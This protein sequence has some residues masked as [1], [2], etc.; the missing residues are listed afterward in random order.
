M[1]LQGL[2]IYKCITHKSVS[3]LPWLQKLV[4]TCKQPHRLNI[5]DEPNPS[6]MTI[7]LLLCLLAPPMRY[8]LNL[9]PQSPWYT[10]IKIA[11]YMI[12]VATICEF[13][14]KYMTTAHKR[15]KYIQYLLSHL[16]KPAGKALVTEVP[17]ICRKTHVLLSRSIPTPS[18]TKSQIHLWMQTLTYSIW[19]KSD[20]KKIP[21]ILKLQNNSN[22]TCNGEIRSFKRT[23]F[24][25]KLVL[26]FVSFQMIVVSKSLYQERGWKA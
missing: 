23:K 12:H 19:S 22:V 14:Y 15:S 7:I 3:N 6:S 9:S 1:A 20:A 18:T 5:F 25:R 13:W 8:K 24:Q 26:L 10:Y 17:T 16:Q 2:Q 11:L 4:H 21:Y